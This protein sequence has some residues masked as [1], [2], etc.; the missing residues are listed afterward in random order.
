MGPVSRIKQFKEIETSPQFFGLQQNRWPPTLI[1]DSPQEALSRLFML[2]GARYVDPL[3]S[4]KF[5]VPPGGIGFLNSENLGEKYEGNLFVGA[6]TPN[7][8]GGHLFRFKL[9]GDRRNLVFDDPR[10]Q[11]GVA[12][13]AA[14]HDITESETLLFGRNFGVG[15]DIRTGP[16]GNLFVVSISKGAIFEI[17]RHR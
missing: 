7:S 8:V 13:N 3:F 2:P 15:T 4:W 11:D 1:A 16:N 12:D 10:L 14:K 17:F 5:T 6:A 9:S